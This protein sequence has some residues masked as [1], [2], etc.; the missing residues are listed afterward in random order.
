[1][2]YCLRCAREIGEGHDFC[3]Y[4]GSSQK[5]NRRVESKIEN[6]N[7]Q[8][9]TPIVIGVVALFLFILGAVAFFEKT[10]KQ[11]GGSSHNTVEYHQEKSF[12]NPVISVSARQILKD[13]E[14]NEIRAGDQYNGKRVRIA[15]CAA[16]IDNML[17]VLSIS[18]N[19]C[20]G[21]FDID[22]VHAIF[23]NIAKSQ[24]SRL[25]KGQKVVVECTIDD[26]G[27]IMGVSAS[28]CIL[29]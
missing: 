23:P 29:K 28:N 18:I 13:F 22:Y 26:G 16:A 1:M 12:S 5:E 25:N 10:D 6:T 7:K 4:C 3:P 21:D 19:S 20:G 8:S 9:K 14:N 15:G 2:K 11:I 17:G 27:D 24:L